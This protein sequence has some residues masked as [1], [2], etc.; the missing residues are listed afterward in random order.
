MKPAPQ[1]PIE[2]RSWSKQQQHLA[3]LNILSHNL[4][5]AVRSDLLNQQL[6]AC[7]AGIQTAKDDI[8][9]IETDELATSYQQ[10][11]EEEMS[12]ANQI[13]EDHILVFFVACQLYITRVTETV[14]WFK[15]LECGST[16]GQ[17]EQL[18]EKI[19]KLKADIHDSSTLLR[20][21]GTRIAKD[22]TIAECMWH[23]GN[24]AKHNDELGWFRRE[25]RTGLE[26]LDVCSH[27]GSVKSD[28]IRRGLCSVTGP[29]ID[30]IAE[31]ESRLEQIASS[32]KAW[33]EHLEDRIISDLDDYF[34]ADPTYTKRLNDSFQ[35]ML[36][37]QNLAP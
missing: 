20:Q 8:V 17:A 27:D 21:F 9:E 28:A 35:R 2:I 34:F 25:T 18:P 24:Y 10:I 29:G 37:S 4:G 7:R 1:L 13:L 6:A 32:L 26:K 31:I 22:M 15:T 5:A 30:S 3:L 16:S 19:F 14:C 11:Y 12:S 33:A 23:L 36:H